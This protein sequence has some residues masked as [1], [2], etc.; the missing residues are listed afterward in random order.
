MFWVTPS[1]PATRKVFVVGSS[2][3]PIVLKFVIVVPEK[4][5]AFG[6]FWNV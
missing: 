1:S 5:P 3:M 2:A 4:C 6:T